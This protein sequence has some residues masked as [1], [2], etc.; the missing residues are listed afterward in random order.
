[1][2]NS[3]LANG[4][5]ALTT[6]VAI[7]GAVLSVL[8]VIAVLRTWSHTAAIRRALEEI[9]ASQVPAVQVP[10]AAPQKPRAF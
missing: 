9:R 10:P 3:D 2:Y 5:V 7:V 6:V 8:L 1:M 4:L